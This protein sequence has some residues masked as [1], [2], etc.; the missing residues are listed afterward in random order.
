MT[1]LAAYLH[2]RAGTDLATAIIGLAG[3]AARISGEIRAPHRALDAVAG[4]RGPE[5]L[6]P[7]APHRALDAVAGEVNTDGDAQKALDVLADEIIL[8]AARQA[9]AAAYMSEEREAAIPLAED[10]PFI[11]TCD[12]LDGSSNIGVNVSIGTIFSV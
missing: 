11:I 3:A 12:P 5:H 1:N 8:E 4:L 6:G 7:R 2:S 10:E 9:G